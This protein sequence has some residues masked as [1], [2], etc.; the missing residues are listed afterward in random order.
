VKKRLIV[1][2]D[3]NPPESLEAVAGQIRDAGFDVDTILSSIGVITGSASDDQIPAIRSVPG[4]A[5][6]EPDREV[7]IG[8]PGSPD[9]Y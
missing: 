2:V 6:V 5:A 1:T 9:T 4:V 3:E 7:D 8:P